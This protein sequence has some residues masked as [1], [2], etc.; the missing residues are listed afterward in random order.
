MA[1][2]TAISIAYDG[3]ESNGRY[4]ARVEGHDGVGELTFQRL[5][6]TRINANRTVVDDR[7]RG[8][9]V[10]TALVEQLV[11]D[12]RENGTSIVPSCSFVKAQF[13]RHP[14]WSDLLDS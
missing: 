8:M 13:D 3:D 10:A 12:A 2:K 1:M 9:G 5:S 14:E 4:E 7:L 6:P 11:K